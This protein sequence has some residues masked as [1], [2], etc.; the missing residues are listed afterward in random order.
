MM[1]SMNSQAGIA[2]LCT[3]SFRSICPYLDPM[4][5]LHAMILDFLTIDF[6]FF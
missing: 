5:I 2:V 3:D 4:A 1:A 6:V